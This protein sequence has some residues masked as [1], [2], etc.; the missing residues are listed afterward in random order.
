[1]SETKNLRKTITNYNKAKVKMLSL[2]NI[3]S[4][5]ITFSTEQL[6]DSPYE[7]GGL[8]C[9]YGQVTRDQ[10]QYVWCHVSHAHVLCKNFGKVIV[11]VS[12]DLSR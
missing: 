8:C 1:M 3:F 7:L 4:A 2:F 5:E 11:N 10:A 12:L 9:F 6:Q